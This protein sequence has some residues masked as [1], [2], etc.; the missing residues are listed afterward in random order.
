MVQHRRAMS[1]APGCPIFGAALS[2][3]RW[4]IAQ[5]AIRLLLQVCQDRNHRKS[6]KTKR[7]V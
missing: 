3:R 6:H 4:A 1:R 5:S 7:I 2:R